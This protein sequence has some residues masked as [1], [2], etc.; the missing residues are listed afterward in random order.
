MVVEDPARPP[1]GTEIW[2]NRPALVVSAPQINDRA[3]FVC[4]VYL[5]RSNNKRVSPTHI[6][7]P[8]TDCPE[9]SMALC[10]QVHTVDASRLVRR[11]GSVP[12]EYIG[13]VDAAIAFA[14]SLRRNPDTYGLFKK[15]EAHIKL[16]GLDMQ[17]A[18]EALMGR[19]SDE[20]VEALQRALELMTT[21]RDAYRELAKTQGALPEAM[22]DVARTTEIH[23]E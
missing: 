22:A 16:H 3:G 23:Q 12:S 10:E 18:V 1:V 17:S 20:R 2:S 19:T 11:L 21:Q 14:L 5:S 9:M 8:S 13:E 15:W 6:E 7:V 4:V